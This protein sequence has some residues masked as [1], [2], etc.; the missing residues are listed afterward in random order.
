MSAPI[1][2]T[3]QS[4]LPQAWRFR[5]RIVA[6]RNRGAAGEESPATCPLW[7]E[8]LA[9]APIAGDRAAVSVVV[10]TTEWS[11]GANPIFLPVLSARVALLYGVPYP[12]AVSGHGLIHAVRC[13]A[14]PDGQALRSTETVHVVPVVRTVR[15]TGDSGSGPI[16]N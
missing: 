9:C 4:K 16:R 13:G 6:P 3:V 14:R 7:S 11:R 2:V 15:V 12:V 8:L 5:S 1:R 10:R